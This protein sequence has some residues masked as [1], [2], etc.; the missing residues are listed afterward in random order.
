[1]IRDYLDEANVRLVGLKVR[2][3][4]GLDDKGEI[5]LEACLRYVEWDIHLARALRLKTANF[6]GG[7]P[8]VEAKHLL[9]EGV[10]QM[11]KRIP[12]VRLNVGNGIN[13]CLQRLADFQEIVP[14]L[15]PRANVWLDATQ[16]AEAIELVDLYANRIGLVTI[17]VND[18]ELVQALQA[19]GY[20]GPLVISVQQPTTNPVPVLK[21]ICQQVNGQL[22]AL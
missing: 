11:L 6:R 8:S 16:L 9:M 2:N 4:T 18:L 12:D 5:N 1:M 20:K 19:N 10:H 15:P 13:T 17:G 7:A 22:S 21:R 3:L 14:K